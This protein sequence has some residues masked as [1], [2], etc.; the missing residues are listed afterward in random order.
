MRL[1]FRK[2]KVGRP[3]LLGRAMTGAERQQRHRTKL[4]NEK[5]LRDSGGT[6]IVSVTISHETAL[7]PE[8]PNEQLSASRENVSTLPAVAQVRDD[9][10][11][12]Q[13]FMPQIQPADKQEDTC[14]T[15]GCQLFKSSFGSKCLRCGTVWSDISAE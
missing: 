13:V 4:R 12:E 7:L 9:G 15:S 10:S 5:L 3:P 11:I 6:S 1:W 8:Q 2:N 14:P